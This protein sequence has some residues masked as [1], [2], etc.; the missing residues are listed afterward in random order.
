[1]AQAGVAGRRQRS[2]AAELGV[3]EPKICIAS[4]HV[5]KPLPLFAHQSRTPL[6]N[7]ATSVWSKVVPAH[8]ER[9]TGSSLALERRHMPDERR[10]GGEHF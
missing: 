4:A 9:Y 2:A 1:M 7:S 8:L 5:G 3:N 6:V 10:D